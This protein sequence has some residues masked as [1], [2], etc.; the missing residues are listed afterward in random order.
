MIQEQE[1]TIETKSGSRPVSWGDIALLFRSTT[2]LSIYQDALANAGI[3]HY[4]LGGGG[5]Y[6]R[7][8]VQDVLNMLRWIENPKDQV[9]LAGILRSPF[10][11]LSDEAL[12][13][14]TRED[15][16]DASLFTEVPAELSGSDLEGFM[17]ARAL[18]G[19]SQNVQPALIS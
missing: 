9:A 15:S 11:S 5:Y 16:L 8:E 10:F 1:L 3:P 13:W 17:E 7:Q 6:A 14:L 2:D 4:V 12:F 19:V 18:L